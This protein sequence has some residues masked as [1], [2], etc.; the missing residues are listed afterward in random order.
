MSTTRRTPGVFSQPRP[1]GPNGERLCFNCRGPMPSDKRKFNCSKK[2]SDEWTLR[3]SPAAM[4]SRVHS[5]DKGACALCGT[6][7]EALKREYLALPR[8]STDGE[9]REAWLEA[10]GIPYGRASGDFW[11]ADHITPVIE[12]GGECG[13]E[14]IRTLCLPCHKLATRELSERRAV[15][16]HARKRDERD[17]AR[18]LFADLDSTDTGGIPDV[19]EPESFHN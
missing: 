5:R 4:R 18:T 1:V 17:N 8:T 14:N 3:T 15:E 7:T 12:G 16:R 11:D 2:C 9:R 13:I 6:D 19:K 10:H